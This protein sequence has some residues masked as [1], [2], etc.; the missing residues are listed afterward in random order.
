MRQANFVLLGSL[1]ER[2]ID[3]EQTTDHESHVYSEFSEEF[4]YSIREAADGSSVENK[5]G[6][7]AL[8]PT[9]GPTRI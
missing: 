7:S 1:A 4:A 2:L 9:D 6:F 5:N 3:F 8:R